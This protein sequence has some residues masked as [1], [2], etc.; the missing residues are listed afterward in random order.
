MDE[1]YRVVIADDEMVSRGYMELF[2]KPSKRYEI[3]GA[4]PFA[5]DVIDWCGKNPLP[6]LIILDVMMAAGIDG[7]TAAEQIKQNYPQIR[8]IAATS[9]ADTDWLEKARQIGVESFW[10]KT[11]SDVSLLEVMDRTMAGES[12]YPEKAPGVMLG[13][14]P[15]G[16]LTKQ[17]RSLLRHLIE[18]LSNREIAEQMHL[19]PN[20]VKDYL[21]DLM[22]KSG[23]HSRTALVAQAS[24]LG[25]VVSD[26]E[27]MKATGRRTSEKGKK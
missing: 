17:Q 7:L 6:D 23:I 15:A 25:I 18:G 24:R 3:A 14:L 16:D 5:Q 26:A 13:R 22:D 20:T 1:P 9:M 21:D 12:V 8:I 2:I 27:R 11:Y 4:L 10:F 19:S